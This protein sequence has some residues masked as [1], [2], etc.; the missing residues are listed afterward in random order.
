[1]VY[2]EKSKDFDIKEVE[3]EYWKNQQIGQF[4]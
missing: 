2:N 1:V 4:Y 3:E